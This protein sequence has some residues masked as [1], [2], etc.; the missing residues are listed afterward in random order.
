MD[1][2]VLSFTELLP[3][4]LLCRGCSDSTKSVGVYIV[5]D[6]VADLHSRSLLK[7]FDKAH[8][9]AWVEHFANDF[10][11][12]GHGPAFLR[13]QLNRYFTQAADCLSV[14]YCEG[15]FELTHQIFYW[16]VALLRNRVKLLNNIHRTSYV[17]VTK[18]AALF[19]AT[20]ALPGELPLF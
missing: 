14:G 3:Q 12:D 19:G 8:L 20:S 10:L 4:H 5:F 2:S 15:L 16:D 18:K 11:L 7:G 6:K 13:V 17:R 1:T 9:A